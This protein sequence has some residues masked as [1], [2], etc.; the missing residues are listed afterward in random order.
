MH[1]AV[2][3]LYVA[4]SRNDEEFITVEEVAAILRIGVRQASRYGERVT[5]KRAGKRILYNREQILEIAEEIGAFNKVSLPVPAEMV[6]VGE[7]LETFER[8]QER[9][10][11]LALEVGRLQGLLE[12]AQRQLVDSDG[13][14]EQLSQLEQ[15]RTRLQAQ[16]DTYQEILNR[17]SKSWWRRLFDSD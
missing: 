9:I 5:T 14:K 12:A 4:M 16:V 13:V 6:P 3:L 2:V 7:M 15:E 1:H 10:Q 8:Q 11:Q 17:P